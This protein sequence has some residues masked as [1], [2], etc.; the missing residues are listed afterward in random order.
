L[1]KETKAS[2]GSLKGQAEENSRCETFLVPLKEFNIILSVAKWYKELRGKEKNMSSLKYNS[3]VYTEERNNHNGNHTTTER[4]YNRNNRHRGSS[5]HGTTTQKRETG[6]IEKLLNSYGFIEYGNQEA[7][8]F[9]HYSEY[10]GS[11]QELQVGGPVEFTA[12]SDYKNNR[13]VAIRVRPLPAGSV[14]IDTVCDIPVT[15]VVESEARPSSSSQ[16]SDQGLGTV[17]YDRNGE[18]MFLPFSLRD[19]ERGG[20]LT[21]G[22]VVSFLIAT[23]RRNGSLKARKLVLVEAAEKPKIHGIVSSLKDS[24]GFIERADMVAEIFFHY[25]EFQGDIGEL[26]IGDDVEFGMQQRKDK[27]VA[28]KV[29]KLPAGAVVFEDISKQKY[30]GKVVKPV[31]Q[32]M[33]PRGLSQ[34]GTLSGVIEFN[35][36]SDTKEVLFGDRDTEG[37]IQ[38]RTGDTVEFN[39][40]TDRRDGLQRAVNIELVHVSVKNGEIRENGIVAILKE[41]FGFIKC[42]DRDLSLFFHFSELLEQAKI[43]GIGDEVEFTIA[44]DGHSGKPHATRIRTLPKGTVN[45]DVVTIDDC[46]GVVDKEPYSRNNRRDGDTGSILYTAETEVMQVL[47]RSKDCKLNENPQHGDIVR[48]QLVQFKKTGQFVAREIYVSQ[49]SLPTRHYGFIC[50]LKENFGFIEFANHETEIF[51]HF[52]ELNCESHELNLGDEVEF[53]TTK[54]NGKINAERIIKIPNGSIQQEEVLPDVKDGIVIKPIRI[55]DPEQDEYEGLINEVVKD[56]SC[57]GDSTSS[58]YNFGISSLVNKREPL[59]IGDKVKFQVGINDTGTVQ[60][61]MNVGSVRDVF[62]GKVESLKGQYGFITHEHEQSKN[63]FFHISELI[64]AEEE[65][66]IGDTVEFFIAKTHKNAKCCAIQIR[67]VADESNPRNTL[68]KRLSL[69]PTPKKFY[70]VRQPSLPDGTIGFQS[71]RKSETKD[72]EENKEDHVNNE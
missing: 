65:L 15:G 5:Y 20:T 50:A 14:E 28:I 60:R 51:F 11:P 49:K 19:V 53:S 24:F 71:R 62:K 58:Y 37:D 4:N 59:Q 55:W 41:G 7:R 29:K 68:R 2:K 70:A 35:D 9:F 12:T 63:I 54:K 56:D 47:F 10:N 33:S 27:E 21:K 34:D 25:S 18:V 67:K 42:C 64:N 22:D 40:S 17:S 13:P 16:T 69:P 31:A 26:L 46:Q 44:H 43:L 52:S 30:R 61:A 23:D 66:Q 72:E 6:V 32:K 3:L 45:I 8:I 1:K 48:F 38:L 57:E 36:K 39:T